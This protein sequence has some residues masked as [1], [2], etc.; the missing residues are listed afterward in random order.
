MVLTGAVLL[1]LGAGA[2]EPGDVAAGV[3]AHL[4]HSRRPRRRRLLRADDRGHHAWFD[5]NRSLAVSLV[6][7]GMG[8]APMTISPFARWLISAYDWRTAM[9]AIGIAAWVLLIPAGL[10]VRRPPSRRCRRRRRSRRPATAGCRRRG[11][12]ARRNSSCWR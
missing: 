2:G 7:A 4:R 8:V 9:M 5:T 6:S 1:G 12:S 3:P 10:L 11:A